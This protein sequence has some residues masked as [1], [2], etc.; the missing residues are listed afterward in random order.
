MSRTLLLAVDPSELPEGVDARLRAAAGGM[1]VLVTGERAAME[2]ALDDVEIAA[3][4]AP[5]DLLQRM[6]RLRWLQLWS[7]GA[8]WLP[9]VPE[10]AE[11]DD[12]VVT[13][14]V[15]IHAVQIGEHVFALLLALV[16]DLPDAI[17]AQDAHEWRRLDGP[18]GALRVRELY[19]RTLL[20]VG[21][22]AIGAR[23]AELG[24]AFGMR[25][26]GVRRHP[27]HAVPGVER[28]VGPDAL[29]EVVGEADAVVV[30]LPRTVETEGTFDEALLGRMKR[31][32]LLVN[33]G[34]GGTIDERAL[35][36]ALTEGRL[37]GAGLDVTEQEPLPA[38]A[39]LWDAPNLVITSHYAGLTPRYHERAVALFLDNLRRY[40]AGEPLRNVV[41]KRL[42]A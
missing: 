25:V 4:F 41:D 40:G 12:L 17:R 31:G 22:G 5:R 30:T 27:E 3:G 19:D 15:G 7:A 21:V 2:A 1:R 37:G 33:I 36:R 42:G 11:R 32:A 28:M 9:R 10:L 35:A 34:R 16:R 26:I 38:D 13:S 39:P 8:D 29:A 14:A 6:P 18:A 24:R 23:V 20:V